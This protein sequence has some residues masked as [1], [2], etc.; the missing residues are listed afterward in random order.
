MLLV[1]RVQCALSTTVS[2]LYSSAMLYL[3]MSCSARG[4]QG[5]PSDNDY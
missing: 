4:D 5:D 1:K 3:I 2:P